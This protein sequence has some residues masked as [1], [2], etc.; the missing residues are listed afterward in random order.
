MPA[1]SWNIRLVGNGTGNFTPT[2]Q[3]TVT[4]TGGTS[5]ALPT[6]EQGAFEALMPAIERGK[7]RLF[8]AIGDGSIG[9]NDTADL[10]I[11]ISG[12]GYTPTVTKNATLSVST[13][14]ALPANEIGEA[15]PFYMATE[16]AVRRLLN[17]VGNGD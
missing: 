12:T 15:L 11:T 6:N 8:N 14:V 9:V 4:K 1:T 13:N 3:K 10:T 2:L 17:A 5:Y 16:R 7:R